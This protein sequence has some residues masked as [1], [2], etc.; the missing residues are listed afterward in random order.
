V[1]YISVGQAIEHD[2]IKVVLETVRISKDATTLE[3]W[4]DTGM[5]EP[6]E[7]LS[8]PKLVVD[9]EEVLLGNGGPGKGK[10][11]KVTFGPLPEN[12][13]QLTWEYGPFWGMEDES[14]NLTLPVGQ[15]LA[16]I[17][18][19]RA[20]SGSSAE[21]ERIPLD[22]SVASKGRIYRFT[23]MNI[24]LEGFSLTCVPANEEAAWYPLRGPISHA[25]IQDDQG[26]T[27]IQ[28]TSHVKLAKG[29]G[30][31][32]KEMTLSFK[33]EPDLKASIWSLEIENP[34]VIYQ[35]PWRFDISLP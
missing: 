28:T 33:G 6:I 11:G 16:Q 23:E 9:G 17:I 15:Y 22:V 26:S 12:A 2:E 27:Y 4:Y 14:L 24:G 19:T 35:G 21:T 25:H 29:E 1:E 32:F 13:R 3:A 20:S 18:A 7:P 10:T 30:Y 5:L 34:G 8:S 31:S